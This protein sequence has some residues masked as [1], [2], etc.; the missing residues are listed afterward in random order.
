MVSRRVINVV[1]AVVEER[2]VQ[3]FQ[4]ALHGKVIRPGDEGYDS[5]RRVWNGM[6]DRYPAMIAYCS[7]VDDII[8][9]VRFGRDHGL[10]TTV[11]SGGHNV[12]GNSV[13]DGGLVIDLSGMKRIVVDTTS[14]TARAQAGLNWGEFDRAT[15][16]CGLA[17]TGGIVS[18]TGIAGLTLGGGIGWLMRKFGAT[19]DNLLSVDIVTADGKPLTASTD[20]NQDLFWGLRGGGG[21]F[22]I[23][24]EFEYR[25]HEVGPVVA[26]TLYYPSDKTREILRFYGDFIRSVPDELTTMFA[27]IAHSS[28]TPLYKRFRGAPMLGIHVCYAGN[29]AEGAKVVKPLR[30]LGPLKD[31]VRIMP[32]YELQSML[33]SGAAP[34]LLNYW[35][36]SHLKDL[37]NGA[38]DVLASYCE[39]I[40]SPLSQVH[41]Q[42][43]GGAIGRV[44]EDAMAFGHR[45]ALCVLNV[46][47]K[48][49][50]PR[51]SEKHIAWTRN[52]EDAMRP[53]STGGVY[54]NF[55]G[56]EG[57]DRV[58]SA[59]APA[60]Y[61]RLVAL[62]NRY[63]PTNFFR[64]NQNI[65]PSVV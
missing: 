43:L 13:C 20:E 1:G 53:F 33:D 62:K 58:R 18:R 57:E 38:I 14:R 56:E 11:R 9:S 50:D 59:Y 48:W 15:Q 60:K 21:N 5:G 31:D 63:D 25:L 24:T 39:E 17:T 26:G 45:E 51:E 12:A 2:L 61:D 32:Y 8:A 40:T 10:L 47:T 29:I 28:M 65:K 46:V 42:H 64:M 3:E 49:H 4:R 37:S 16:N 41:L 35:K 23:A 44:G 19:C 52:I 55:L 22:G 54:V 6:I 27:Y 7:D 30:A 36:S 34:G